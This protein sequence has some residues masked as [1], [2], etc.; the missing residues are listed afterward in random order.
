MYER[1]V[2]NVAGKVANP[3]PAETG[4]N[5]AFCKTGSLRCTALEY[6]VVDYLN[7]EVNPKLFVG[8]RSDLPDD[9]KGQ[10]TG[11]PASAPRTRCMRPNTSA[12]R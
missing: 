4:A 2:P 1:D 5:G 6:A 12:A 8:F 10:R 9:K 11:I 3:V 7:R